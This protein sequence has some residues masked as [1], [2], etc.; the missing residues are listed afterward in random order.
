MFYCINF[1]LYVA[2]YKLLFAGVI[3]GL[4]PA[5]ANLVTPALTAIDLALSTLSGAT[6]AKFAIA[7]TT[8]FAT[9]RTAVALA[10]RALEATFARRSAKTVSTGK[11]ASIRASVSTE[12]SVTR[13]L[14]VA[15]VAMVGRASIAIRLVLQEN[16]ARSANKVANAKMAVVAITL[17]GPAS[18]RPGSRAGA[19]RIPARE[20]SMESVAPIA[21]I[22]VT[23]TTP[24]AAIQEPANV[25]V[26]RATEV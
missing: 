8:L 3:R 5:F 10:L 23:D 4:G 6:A 2:N 18:V 16:T 7:K 12:Q 14:D 13:R 24:T 17:T 15:S 9:R 19:A 25:F 1:I 21:A 26:N 22:T 11:S 20:A